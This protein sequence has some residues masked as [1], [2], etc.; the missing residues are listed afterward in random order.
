MS[1]AAVVCLVP[2]LML[3]VHGLD[4][5]QVSDDRGKPGGTDADEREVH[6]EQGRRATEARTVSATG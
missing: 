1:L 5:F 3:A 6:Q 4:A 2:C